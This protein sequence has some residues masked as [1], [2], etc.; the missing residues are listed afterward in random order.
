MSM[1]SEA[2]AEKIRALEAWQ[3]VCGWRAEVHMRGGA[4]AEG[5]LRAADGEAA[6]LLLQ[7]LRTPAFAYAAACVRTSDIA[8]LSLRPQ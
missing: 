2:A 8:L 4:R 1:T 6:T 3:A 5:E 7:G